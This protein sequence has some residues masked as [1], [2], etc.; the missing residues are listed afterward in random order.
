[1]GWNS[2]PPPPPTHRQIRFTTATLCLPRQYHC[3]IVPATQLP[4]KFLLI[5]PLIWNYS[6]IIENLRNAFFQIMIKSFV[7]FRK[8]LTFI[9]NRKWFVLEYGN[10]FPI[11]RTQIKII[12]MIT[13][14]LTSPYKILQK[15]YWVIYHLIFPRELPFCQ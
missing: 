2:P 10:L 5:Q 4:I 13:K 1:M 12:I 11:L 9:F 3:Y 7:R 8:I 6:T 15:I 14:H